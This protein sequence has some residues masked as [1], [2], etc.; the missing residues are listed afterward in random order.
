[1]SPSGEAVDILANLAIGFQVAVSAKALL[2]CFLGV[3]IGTFVGVLPGVG[4]MA[5]VS[6]TLPLTYHLE[7]V[8]ALIMLGGIFYG[9]Q[10]GA[11]ISA[12]LLNIPGTASSSIT[13]IEGHAMTKAGRP[14]PALFMTAIASYFGGTFAII[15]LMVSAPA[16]A[17]FAIRFGSAEYFSIMLLG[18]I[19]ASTIGIGSPLKGLTMVN[20]GLVLGLVGTD[21]NTGQ[22]RFTFGILELSDGI[23]LVSLAM[24]L[25]G[26]SEILSSLGSWHRVQTDPGSVSI[27]S[28][29]PSRE[30][31]RKFLLPAIR[32]SMIGSCV[33]A[34]PGAGPTI[35]AFIAYA[36]EKKVAKDETRFGKGAVEGLVAP[37]SANN[38]SVQAA[39]IPTLSLGVPGDPIMA[40]LLGAMLIQGIAPGPG[41][42]ENQPEIFWG[43]V[44]S[45]WIG[46]LILLVL[47][48]PL[49][50][51][52]VRILSIPYRLLCP[53]MLFFICVGVYSVNGSAFDVYVTIFFGIIG[54]FTS[55]SGYPAAPLLL[56]FVLGPMIE[57]NF[58]RAVVVSG[59]DYSVFFT[60]P[61]SATF[62]LFAFVIL[63][64]TVRRMIGRP[65]PFG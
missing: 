8:V 65:F 31:M 56:G 19:A 45:F 27:R 63:S 52:W 30:E 14:G 33:G 28:L 1:M 54:Y 34:L 48:I 50:G 37:E 20:I 46:N 43:L 17:E 61:L 4:V 5:A 35:A 22:Y 41:F 24:G 49:I 15:L 51:I 18:L 39:F 26:V 13:C 9:A 32:G 12:I 7:P 42:I 21:I 2:F 47:N 64:D 25:F 62:L 55:R 60:N 38:A 16:L 53:A 40:I 44:V 58:R 29:I 6:M 57:E 23:S 3:T 11:A 10:Y 59:G 36:T